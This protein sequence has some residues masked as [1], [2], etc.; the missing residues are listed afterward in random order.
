M[1]IKVY[2]L[3]WFEKQNIPFKG[4]LNKN[5]H[6]KEKKEIVF[7][8]INVDHFLDFGYCRKFALLPQLP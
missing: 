7:T 1:E 5:L 2:N 3:F 6:K 8:I 4:Y